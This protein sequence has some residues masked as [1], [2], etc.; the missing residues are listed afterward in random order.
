MKLVYVDMY[1]DA[2]VQML[3]W[4]NIYI[5]CIWN[6]IY[7]AGSIVKIYC[8]I[9]C[10]RLSLWERLFFSFIASVIIIVISLQ[11]H[12]YTFTEVIIHLLNTI[13]CCSLQIK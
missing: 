12:I 6:V 3:A 1:Q 13:M 7:S 5:H 10:E 9:T 11:R 8:D 4:G 2:C